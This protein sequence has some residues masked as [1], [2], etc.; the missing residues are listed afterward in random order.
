MKHCIPSI[1]VERRTLLREGLAAFLHDTRYKVIA[2]LATVSDLSSVN[3]LAAR[4]ALILLGL[5]DGIAEALKAVQEVGSLPNRKVV[6]VA[7]FAGTPEIQELLR[8]G[9]NGVIVN[10]SS[11]DVFI[12][13]LDLAFLDQEFVV[14]GHEFMPL[15]DPKTEKAPAPETKTCS[16]DSNGRENASQGGCH[17]AIV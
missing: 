2:T 9:A 1:I 13:A 11:R 17:P 4:P 3:S 6:V 14:I 15:A 12:K 10:V 8:S 7:E 16:T 5:W